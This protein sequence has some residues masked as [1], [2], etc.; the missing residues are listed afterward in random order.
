MGFL[1]C[2]ACIFTFP[3]ATAKEIDDVR[4]AV[5]RHYAR[6]R[7]PWSETAGPYAK[8]T[9]RLFTPT[10]GLVDGEITTVGTQ[11]ATTSGSSRTIH[12]AVRKVDGQWEIVALN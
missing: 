3:R 2:A 12:I 7:R 8:I 10:F 6:D 9:L 4:Y 11:I 5:E 1:I